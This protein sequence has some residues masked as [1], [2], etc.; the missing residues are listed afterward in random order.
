V[1]L[2]GLPERGDL[3]GHAVYLDAH[4]RIRGQRVGVWVAAE[5]QVVGGSHRVGARTMPM[6]VGLLW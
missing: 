3:G 4:G 2:R 5:G 1:S 6:S